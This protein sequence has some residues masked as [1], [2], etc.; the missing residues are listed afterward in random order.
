MTLSVQINHPPLAMDEH[1][2]ARIGGTRVTLD[3]VIGAYKSGATAEII[4]DQ[5]PTLKLEDVYFAIGFYLSHTHEV[6][7]YLRQG[8]EEADRVRAKIDASGHQ[9]DLRERL[10]ARRARKQG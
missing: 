5:Y 6:E 7:D 2:V 9:R 8:E 3:T 1:G 4:V 10:L